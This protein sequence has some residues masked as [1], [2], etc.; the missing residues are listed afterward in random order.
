MFSK[1]LYIEKINQTE[2]HVSMC[3]FQDL[4]KKVYSDIDFSNN[5]YLEHIRTQEVDPSE[6]HRC[7]RNEQAGIQSYRLGQQLAF[8]TQQIETEGSTELLSFSYN[9]ENTCNLTCIT[10]GPKFSSK[11]KPE[12]KLLGYPTT[13]IERKVNGHRN[14]LYKNLDLTKVRLM[15]FQGGEPLL[16]EDHKNILRQIGDLSR[17]VVSYNTNATVY[18]GNDAIELWQQ[19]ELTKLYFSIDATSDQF[20]Y[21]RYPANWDQAVNNMQRIRG[22]Q[23][24]NLWIELGV[25]VSIASLFYLQD[26]INWRDQHFSKLCTDDPV[27]IYLGFAGPLSHGGN[28]LQ[29]TNI[30]ERLKDAALEYAN[31]LTD[32]VIRKSVLNYIKQIQPVTDMQWVNYLDQIDSIRNTNWKTSLSKLYEITKRN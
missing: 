15:H 32:R 31:A 27:N 14:T 17:T 6:C 29:L 9:C 3:C 22:L 19:T 12:Y 5:D 18:P 2:A 20:E 25:T 21:I 4:S 16:T 28:M 10:C 24:P 26:I 13:E 11:W 7:F 1:G 8:E 30:D 23:I